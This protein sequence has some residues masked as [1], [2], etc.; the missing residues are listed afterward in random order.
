LPSDPFVVDRLILYRSLLS[1]RGATYER[2]AQFPLPASPRVVDI[3]SRL[4]R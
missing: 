1:P 2:L 4:D 3:T